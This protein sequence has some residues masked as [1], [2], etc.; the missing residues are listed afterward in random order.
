[1]MDATAT[2]YPEIAGYLEERVSEHG[3][4]PPER[5]FVLDHIARRVEQRRKKAGACDATFICTH[6]SRRS[7]FA[8]VWAAVAA[9]TQGVRGVRAHSGGTEVTAFNPRAVA[10]L[11]RAGLRAVKTTDGENPI[12][13]VRFSD[14]AAPLTCFSKIYNHA[15]NP[16]VGY[17]A[18]MTCS[19]ADA[20]CPMVEG[21][22]ERIA[23]PYEDP[24]V[25]DDTP[26]ETRRYDER[27]AQIAREL[28][29][30]FAKIGGNQ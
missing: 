9:A 25:A 6:N 11:Q 12:Y 5:R 16:P 20:E 7:Q 30:V 13:H 23:L 10:A 14:D 3:A 15:P 27:C 1:M 18:V 28:T 2:P 29:Y 8:Q 4:I 24:K 19:Q 17:I 22:A 26:D 21:A